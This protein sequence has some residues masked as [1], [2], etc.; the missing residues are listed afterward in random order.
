MALAGVQTRAVGSSEAA[1]PS[2]PE[3]VNRVASMISRQGDAS[4]VASMTSLP[5][6]E[7]DVVSMSMELAVALLHQLVQVRPE[8]CQEPNEGAPAAVHHRRPSRS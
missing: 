4:R 3:G 7:S 8:E 5:A 2:R 1:V 6:G